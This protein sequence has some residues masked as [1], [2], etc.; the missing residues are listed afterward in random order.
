MNTAQIVEI[1]KQQ[2]SRCGTNDPF[3]ICKELG[4]EVMF[5]SDFG[6]LKGMYSVI[7]KN[8]FIFIN[9]DLDEKMQKIVCAHELGH[10]SLH[11]HLAV[12]KTLREFMLYDMTSTPE[13]EANI[14]A[15]EILLDT[16]EILENVYNYNY[17]VE[18][19]AGLMNSDVNL[20]A[21]KIGYLCELGHKFNKPQHKSYFLG[22]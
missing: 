9:E 12:G 2:I 5:C 1:A 13:Y 17:S 11:R 4:I 21:L 8:R 18:Q 16:D 10:D 3:K 19:I 15:A 22:N 20:V 14:F 6:N 7:K